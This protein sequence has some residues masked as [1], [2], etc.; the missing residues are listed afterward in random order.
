ME[1]VR[2]LER[3][4]QIWKTSQKPFYRTN[5]QF[6]FVI[7]CKNTKTIA[8]VMQNKRLKYL[9]MLLSFVRSLK[10]LPSSVFLLLGQKSR[11]GMV[12]LALSV[13]CGRVDRARLNVSR[14]EYLN[15]DLFH[16]QNVRL[17]WD[18]FVSKLV[19]FKIADNFKN[20]VVGATTKLLELNKNCYIN[21]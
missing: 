19:S 10:I 16:V 18:C 13:L 2:K 8:L 17:F 3:V 20:Q 15:R 7:V 14:L 12:T 5:L 21:L 4:C 6:C 11:S 9:L 1:E